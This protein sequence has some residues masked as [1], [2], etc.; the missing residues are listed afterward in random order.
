MRASPPNTA[1]ACSA[2]NNSFGNL[3]KFSSD[4]YCSRSEHFL[5][6]LFLKAELFR[7]FLI[8]IRSLSILSTHAALR[9]LQRM[10]PKDKIFAADQHYTGQDILR[11]ELCLI[12][13]HHMRSLYHLEL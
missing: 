1:E 11:S 6:R 8:S 13:N 10:A 5:L 2:T 12:H 7:A 9:F 4:I 3:F